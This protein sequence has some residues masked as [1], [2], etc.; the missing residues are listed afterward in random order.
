MTRYTYIFRPINQANR[1]RFEDKRQFGCLNTFQAFSNSIS[2]KPASNSPLTMI[3]AR[4]PLRQSIKFK[5]KARYQERR[6]NFDVVLL[7]W[8]LKLYTLLILFLLTFIVNGWK[9]IW[10]RYIQ[11]NIIFSRFFIE[12]VDEISPRI[13]PFKRMYH[14]SKQTR[15][16]AVPE[17]MAKVGGSL[18]LGTCSST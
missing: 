8:I 3:S 11:T 12:M 6:S 4:F 5:E 1:V 16:E 10:K 15:S 13:I 9:H 18:S 7:C 2:W 17:Y 14:M